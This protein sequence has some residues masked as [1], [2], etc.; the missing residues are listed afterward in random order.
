[1][2]KINVFTLKWEADKVVHSNHF[3][4]CS[5]SSRKSRAKFKKRLLFS[6]SACNELGSC[7]FILT[8]SKKLNQL[9]KI[10]KYSSIHDKGEDTEQ[11]KD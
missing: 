5:G 2:V 10:S 11:I 6:S 9:K 3:K 7:Q 4:Y 8:T 1:M